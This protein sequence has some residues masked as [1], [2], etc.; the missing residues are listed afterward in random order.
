MADRSVCGAYSLLL[1]TNIDGLTM[2]GLEVKW[3]EN[4][5]YGWVYR[6]MWA[7]IDSLKQ[8]YTHTTFWLVNFCLCVII[9]R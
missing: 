2:L 3:W 4:A 7:N 8:L 1:L 5:E 6:I 9:C